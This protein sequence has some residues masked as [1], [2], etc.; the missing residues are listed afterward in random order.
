MLRRSGTLSRMHVMRHAVC[1]VTEV[2]MCSV[3]A[4][5]VIFSFRAIGDVSSTRGP[6]LSLPP[7]PPSPA[8]LRLR[9]LEALTDAFS[10]IASLI[11]FQHIAFITRSIA[12]HA[13]QHCK[14]VYVD[15]RL[16]Q[17]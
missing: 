15:A 13:L 16:T 10:A 1:L 3:T 11:Y 8:S 6:T 17:S 12:A 4:A 9:L 2:F 14:G 5:D 7:S